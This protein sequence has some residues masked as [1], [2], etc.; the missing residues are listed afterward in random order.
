MR[1]IEMK[2]H[3]PDIQMPNYRL[4]SDL[5]KTTPLEI[6]DKA[7]QKLGSQTKDLVKGSVYVANYLGAVRYTFNLVV[8]S[9]NNY[10]D[11][12]F[13]VM[14]DT[15]TLGYPVKVYQSISDNAAPISTKCKN[16]PEFVDYLNNLF[17]SPWVQARITHWMEMAEERGNFPG[18]MHN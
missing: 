11:S 1:I 3:I 16:E 7:A 18:S 10:T 17:S 8:P 9:L 15:V 2:N 13:Y 5:N 6:L 4:D 14:M 12:L